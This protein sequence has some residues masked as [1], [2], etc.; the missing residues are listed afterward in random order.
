MAEAEGLPRIK[1]AI[2]SRLE[3]LTAKKINRIKEMIKKKQSCFI[4]YFISCLSLL[5]PATF[6]Y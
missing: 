1:N 2:S 5:I 3:S 4:F 6:P